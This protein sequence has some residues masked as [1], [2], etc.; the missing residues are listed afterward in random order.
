MGSIDEV[1]ARVLEQSFESISE[2]VRQC[3]QVIGIL[4]S[5]ESHLEDFLTISP[6]QVRNKHSSTAI[7]LVKPD[8]HLILSS[9]KD[10]VKTLAKDPESEHEQSKNQPQEDTTDVPTENPAS[11][12]IRKEFIMRVLVMLDL[13]TQPANNRWKNTTQFLT[14]LLKWLEPL[15]ILIISSTQSKEPYHFETFLF[16]LKTL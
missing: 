1:H 12:K 4:S 11:Q 2:E 9:I 6:L 14:D 16:R 5:D 15:S 8:S 7:A 3:E 10:N 13:Y